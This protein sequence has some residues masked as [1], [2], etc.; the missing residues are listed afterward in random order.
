LDAVSKRTDGFRVLGRADGQYRYVSVRPIPGYPLFVNMSITEATALA[1]WT[2]RAATIGI[3]SA[4]L[5]LCSLYLLMAIR[6]QVRRLS[7][8]QAS[9]AQTS[10][11]L[12]AALNNMPQGL[13][14]FDGGQRMVVCN[15]RFTEMYG[16]APRQT[17]T[18]TRLVSILEARAAVG[19]S[20]EKED[21]A[22]RA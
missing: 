22:A 11:Q 15:R 19:T 16:L 8:S 10:Q 5:L 6:R 14:M 18:G 9:L 1:G 3:G 21:G 17:Q 2:N 13:V 12:D 7:Y 4:A 20:C